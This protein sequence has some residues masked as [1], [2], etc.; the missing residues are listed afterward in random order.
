MKPELACPMQIGGMTLTS[1]IGQAIRPLRASEAKLLYH[2]LGFDDEAAEIVLQSSFE[3]GS[4]I[5]KRYTVEAADMSPPFAWRD[6][7]IGTEELVL[8][9]E[10]Y[11]APLFDP[12]VHMIAYHLDTDGLIEGALPNKEGVGLDRF[13]K[14]GR[15]SL[16]HK[17]YDGAAPPPGHGIHHYVFQ[18]YALNRVLE[19][20][21]A[22][23]RNALGK[24]MIGH[25][26]GFGLL[27]GTFE[28]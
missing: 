4:P 28:R 5:P 6:I 27:I 7:P 8:V 16:G 26:L 21:T 19:F 12:M 11:D 18:L 1:M 3:N 20:E 14:M 13:I 25:V 22:P 2:K 9:M 23:D 24:A 15:N 17:R 10:D